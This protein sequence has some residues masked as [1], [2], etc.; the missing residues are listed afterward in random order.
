M[1]RLAK[2]SVDDVVLD[3]CAGTGGF[4]MEAMEVMSKEAKGEEKLITH[5]HDS[6]LYGFEIDRTLFA[7]ACSNM[8]LHGDGKSNMIFGNSLIEKDSEI[9]REFKE[10]YKP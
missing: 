1:V 8:F 5:I 7:L 4:L 6:Q 3:T 10:T 2:L 9:Y